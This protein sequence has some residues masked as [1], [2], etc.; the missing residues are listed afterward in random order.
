MRRL[1]VFALLAL[2]LA[3]PL[4]AR[5][6]WTAAAT[7][8]IIGKPAITSDSAIFASYDG[9]IYSFS[10]K[11]GAILWTFDTQNRMANGV[12]MIAPDKVAAIAI[13]GTAYVL[14]SANGK[15]LA[16][17]RLG[18]KPVGFSASDNR[19][20]V[21]YEGG[22]SAI[23]QTGAVLWNYS[24]D[25]TPGQIESGK[26]RVYFT[27]GQKLHSLASASGTAVWIRDAGDSFVSRP[28]ENNGKV[29][30]GTTDGRVYGFDAASGM[31]DWNYNTGAWVMSTPVLVGNALFFG[32]NDGYAYSVTRYGK[33]R[34]KTPVSGEVWS[35][36]VSYEQN[37][38]NIVV[39][40]TTEGRIYGI[41]GQTGR[42]EWVTT[43]YGKPS[44]VAL[45]GTNLVFG[46]DRG[47]V[48][49][50]SVNEMCGFTWP[51]ELTI[52]GA[53]PVEVEGK[54]SAEGGVDHVELRVAGGPWMAAEG[55]ED[56]HAVL[57]LDSV[58][59][60]T[61]E[62]QCRARAPQSASD[63]KEYSTLTLIK[64]DNALP[65]KMYVSAPADANPL[66]SITLSAQDVRGIDLR[67]VTIKIENSV[68]SGDSPFSV[69]LGKSGPAKI[70]IEKPGFE[71][72][73][74]V[75]IGKSTGEN[76]FIVGTVI[77][78][79]LLGAAIVIKRRM[80]PKK[81]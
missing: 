65:M 4:F 52:V 27:S 11:N 67:N 13:D 60:G 26:G 45:S 64:S 54:A 28:Y 80:Q 81:K 8:A 22:V 3:Q 55:K 53:W 66:E 32:S 42:E 38:R 29:Y 18:R 41:D 75:V 33:F 2:A 5:V 63:A 35:Q 30:I 36:P 58:E 59:P 17:T 1:L 31:A 77:L 72:A 19:M 25:G 51:N 74:V 21:G 9:R 46:T 48:Y 78:I 10:L 50:I 76:P 61:A 62:I 24:L 15:A 6:E 40:P 43:T 56:W 12:E 79:V 70:T 37:S 71:T 16:E 44:E 49:S 20:Y 73:T 69:V 57:N 68:Q 39:F 23:S 47:K 34:F 14:G 7:G